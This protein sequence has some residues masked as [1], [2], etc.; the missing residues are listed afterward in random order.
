MYS[1]KGF[2]LWWVERICLEHVLIADPSI[3]GTREQKA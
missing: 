3:P 1:G 2:W